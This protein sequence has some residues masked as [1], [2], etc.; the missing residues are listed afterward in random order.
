MVHYVLT[1][2]TRRKEIDYDPIVVVYGFQIDLEMLQY[3]MKVVVDALN[4]PQNLVRV[5]RHFVSLHES[6]GI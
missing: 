6:V 3:R 1:H 2:I 4:V 5:H